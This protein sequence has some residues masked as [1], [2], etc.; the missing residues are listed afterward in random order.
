MLQRLG[1]KAERFDLHCHTPASDGSRE[2]IDLL[3][4]AEKAGLD[5]IS[6]T[7]HD[8]LGIYEY[9]KDIDPKNWFSGTI[10]NGVEIT[11]D[12]DGERLEVLGYNYNY[13]KLKK[14]KIFKRAYDRKLVNK[15]IKKLANKA[16]AM[17][18]VCDPVPEKEGRPSIWAPVYKS[19]ME[20]KDKNA[21][22]IEKYGISTPKHFSRVLF[23]QK[24]QA[25][26]MPA[27]YAPSVKK[28][29]KILHKC[30]GF[31]ILAHPYNYGISNIEE[32]I[33]RFRSEGIIDGLECAHS[34]HTQ[35]QIKFLV[36]Y[37]DKYGLLKTAGSDFHGRERYYENGLHTFAFGYL[38][39]RT[40]LKPITAKMLNYKYKK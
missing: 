23:S 21:A 1:I 10:I 2:L 12:V 33:D 28:V 16:R 38:G 24:G 31:A 19:I 11:V 40:G 37:C 3:I 34:A 30:G 27:S 35:K 4:D 7:D 13:K 8:T 20:N 29:Y 36:D 18:F 25:F 39:T 17:G 5:A 32:Y 22:L 9:L 26:Y 15:Q 6:F 14:Y